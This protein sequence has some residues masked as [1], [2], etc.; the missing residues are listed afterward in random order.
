[1]IKWPW[2][3]S[4]KADGANYVMESVEGAEDIR[5]PDVK[6][7]QKISYKSA[8]NLYLANPMARKVVEKPIEYAMAKRPEVKMPGC[9]D[10]LINEIWREWDKLKCDDVVATAQRNKKIYGASA[11]ILGIEGQS[12]SV[13]ATPQTV[14]AFPIWFN[15]ADALQM[16]GNIFDLDI[17]SPNYGRLKTINVVGR[18][19]PRGR[20]HYESNG[21]MLYLDFEASNFNFAGRSVYRAIVTPLEAY[22]ESFKTFQRICK[23]TGVI[24]HKQESPALNQ[25]MS[26]QV[27][28]GNISAL[29]N[30][31]AESVVSV[32]AKDSIENL[33]FDHVEDAMKARQAIIEDIASGAGI[34]SKLLLEDSF[35][36][37]L[38]S[39]SEDYRAVVQWIEAYQR[40]EIE[41]L[42]RYMWRVLATR[43]ITEQKFAEYQAAEPELS[44]TLHSEALNDWLQQMEVEWPKLIPQ[45]EQELQESKAKKLDSIQ[46]VYETT[47]DV[48]WYVSEVNALGLF[49]TDVTDFVPQS[50]PDPFGM[51]EEMGNEQV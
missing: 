51:P 46:S 9:P 17:N 6:D 12:T 36:S 15:V 2:A 29:K 11:I 44:G 38:S 28:A 41:P 19:Y 26:H 32:G 20:Y 42:L 8:R 43:V 34:P 7:D 18:I 16:A 10:D 31:D 13:P 5:N 47:K 39:G 21:D 48:D 14:R 1:M 37:L 24:I 33:Q 22:K 49:V 40:K 45:T 25:G 4:V 3:G 30:L 27:R 35:A 23:F 50:E